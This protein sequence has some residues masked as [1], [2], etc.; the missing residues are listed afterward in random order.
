MVVIYRGVSAVAAKSGKL[1]DQR[2][3]NW[4]PLKHK[5][6]VSTVL[7]QLQHV[8]VPGA[9]QTLSP[10]RP[11]LAVIV[12]MTAALAYHRCALEMRCL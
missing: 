6:D 8:A 11:Q 1:L 5:N 12:A 7:G 9:W 4:R 10:S 2:R 3:M